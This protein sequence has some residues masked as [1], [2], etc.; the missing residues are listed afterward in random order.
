M[1]A[2]VILVTGSTDGIG[3]QTAIELARKGYRVI[4]HGRNIIKSLQAV[5]EIKIQSNNEDIEIVTADFTNLKAI[6]EMVRE[7]IRRFERLDVLIN[8]AGVFENEQVILSNGFERTFMVNH[9]APFALTVQLMDL[10]RST[11][12]SRIVNV[13]S[14]AQSESIDF[15]N[16]NGEKYFDPYNA[17]ALSKL[18]NVLFT[19]KLARLLKESTTKVNCLHPGVIRTKLLH[20][21]WGV[22]GNSLQQGAQASV[23]AATSPQMEGKSGLYFVNQKE[24]RSVAI[25][26]DRKIQERLWK[27]SLALTGVNSI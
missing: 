16:L 15:D 10:I 3:K 2:K 17:Y 22:G 23:F 12:N 5:K 21:G 20:A 4:V 18:G 25:S 8:N 6:K 24:T 13:S 11:P 7:I 19:Y 27:V 14:M 9:L 26:Y 1:E